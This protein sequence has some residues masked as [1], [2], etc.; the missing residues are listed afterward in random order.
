[1]AEYDNKAFSAMQNAT[2]SKA[3]N[4]INDVYWEDELENRGINLKEFKAL[5]K[6]RWGTLDR[7]SYKQVKSLYDPDQYRY[8]EKEGFPPEILEAAMKDAEMYM[9]E[10]KNDKVDPERMKYGSL[11]EL[12]KKGGLKG[13]FQRLLPGGETGYEDREVDIR[14][15][16]IGIN[17]SRIEDKI[18]GPVEIP[19][20]PPLFP[21]YGA[22]DRST[23]ENLIT[24]SVY[25][26]GA[27]IERYGKTSKV[28]GK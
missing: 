16:I 18:L 12:K 8:L 20:N 22:E 11:L 26:P 27:S 2:K 13:F 23:I 17:S 28:K 21:H 14:N 1:M 10:M 19:S 7:E 24:D 6:K 3:D 4:V 25:G 5:Y 15:E 9:A